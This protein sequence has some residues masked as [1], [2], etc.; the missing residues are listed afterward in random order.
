MGPPDPWRQQ[1]ARRTLPSAEET[2]AEDRPRLPPLQPSEIRM[3]MET[4]ETHGRYDTD[5]HLDGC[6][7][8]AETTPKQGHELAHNLRLFHDSKK[9][10]AQ[11]GASGQMLGCET[12]RVVASGSQFNLLMEAADEIERLSRSLSEASRWIPVTER[13]PT[14]ESR[15]AIVYRYKGRGHPKA[16]IGDFF[17]GQFSCGVNDTEI[18]HWMPLPEAPK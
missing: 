12:Y 2:P 18:T 6:P 3:S 14:D 16:F 7:E 9:P 4:C 8:C 10:F 1:P 5:T 11:P 17:D 15:Y 13:L